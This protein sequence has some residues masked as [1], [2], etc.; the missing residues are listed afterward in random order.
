MTKFRPCIDL[1]DGKVKQIVGSSLNDSGAGLKTNFETDRSSAWFAELYKK[2]GIKGGHVIMLGKG[3][4]EA[5]KAALAAYPGGLQVGG[6]ISA[7]NA[8]EYLDAGASHVIVTSWIFPEG[9][10]DR[11]RLEALVAVTGKEHLVL[12]LSC[13]R[14]NEPGS[15]PQWSI[16]TNRWQTLIDIQI[17]PENLQDLARYCNEFLVHAADVEGKQ[18]GMDDD[19]IRFLSKH[20]PIK[21]TYAGGAKCLADLEHCKE[22]SDG[23]IDLTIGSALD[24]FGGKGVKYDECV[25]FNQAQG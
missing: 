11:E 22:I 19:L 25:K 2:D 5:A 12:D 4:V 20:S 9:K 24:L 10:L 3:N 6:G 1:H 23:K 7:D 16:A 8:K 18:Q 15:E 13:K 17:T 21:V 14:T